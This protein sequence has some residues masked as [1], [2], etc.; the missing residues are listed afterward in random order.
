MNVQPYLFFNGHAEEALAFYSQAFG[1]QPTALMRY[2]EAP[3]PPPPGMLPP[4]NENK[5]MHAS[6]RV[7]GTELMLSDGTCSGEL[8][9]AGVALAVDTP[10]AVTAR[11]YFDALAAGGQVTMPL[12]PTF[13]SPLFGMVT[14]RYGVAWMVMVEGQPQ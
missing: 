14:D 4:G 6:L 13:W 10:D 5:V 2:N 9:F 1:A 8:Q 3:D 7:G 11:R 12:G